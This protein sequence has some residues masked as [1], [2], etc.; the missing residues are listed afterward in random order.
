MTALVAAASSCHKD[1]VALLLKNGADPHARTPIGDVA[2]TMARL[3]GRV[4][5][6]SLIKQARRR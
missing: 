6:A 1:V 3:Q 2:V 5:I 4:D